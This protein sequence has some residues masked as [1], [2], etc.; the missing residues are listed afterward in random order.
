MA[1]NAQVHIWPEEI[2]AGVNERG[3]VEVVGLDRDTGTV[4]KIEISS[5]QWK[6][7]YA[8]LGRLRGV[9]IYQANRK[10]EIVSDL[11]DDLPKENGDG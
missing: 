9:G 11:P 10:V 3:N 4:V 1:I 5:Q 8:Q 6:H 7:V 2:G